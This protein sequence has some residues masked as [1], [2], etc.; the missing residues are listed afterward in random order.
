MGSRRRKT[1][2][3][4]VG[5]AGIKQQA[6]VA[7]EPPSVSLVIL[8]ALPSATSA[9]SSVSSEHIQIHRQAARSNAKLLNPQTRSKLAATSSK[10]PPSS[11]ITA[12]PSV[13]DGLFIVLRLHA[14]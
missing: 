3:S 7:G 11:S 6:S 4:A 9:S 5:I 14:T 8:S 13:Q 12:S 10:L 1:R 2:T